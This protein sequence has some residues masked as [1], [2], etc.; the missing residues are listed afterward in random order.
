M[1]NVL[2][3]KFFSVPKAII[4]VESSIFSAF[5]EWNV[6]YYLIYIRVPTKYLEF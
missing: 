6:S 1:S 5:L 3:F 4:M 2:L